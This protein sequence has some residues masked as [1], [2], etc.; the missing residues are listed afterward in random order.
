[1]PQ[2]ISLMAEINAPHTPL[3]KNCHSREGGNPKPICGKRK[4][5]LIM[6][7]YL[8]KIAAIA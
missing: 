7:T 5:Q 3:E 2:L 8:D 4:V 1:M 6:F